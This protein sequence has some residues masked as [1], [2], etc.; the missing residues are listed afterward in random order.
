MVNK[1]TELLLFL[2]LLCHY[3]I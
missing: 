1:S 3:Q 2:K